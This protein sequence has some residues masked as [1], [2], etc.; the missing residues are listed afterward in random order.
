M[1]FKTS[2]DRIRNAIYG[3]E[4]RES[5]AVMG[6]YLEEYF[7]ECASKIGDAVQ[8]AKD[9]AASASEAK[10]AL[11]DTKAAKADAVEAIETAETDA[12]KNIV[13]ATTDAQTAA[14][15]ASTS[16]S[17]AAN[18]EKSAA[19]SA[20]A[21]FQSAASARTSAD[22]AE[23]EAQKAA[24]IVSTDKTLAVEGAPADAAATGQA[25]DAKANADHAHD[26]ADI[27]GKP[28]SYT[29]S[30]HSHLYAGSDAAGGTASSVNGFTFAAQTSDPGAGSTLAA[31]TILL[32]YE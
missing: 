8:S 7:H 15:N 4:V 22:K 20:T 5:I 27:T 30:D 21:A 9:A 6:E 25:L 29:P 17:A 2:I 31:G 32:V 10:Q 18:S 11:S 16:A 3:V 28:E 26:W 12:L 13:N 1:D 19:D 23:A 24:A 14:T